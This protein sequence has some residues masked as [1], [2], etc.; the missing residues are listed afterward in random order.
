MNI[1]IGIFYEQCINFLVCIHMNWIR[2]AYRFG[3]FVLFFTCT[4]FFTWI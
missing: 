3:N 1:N 2:S 4:R